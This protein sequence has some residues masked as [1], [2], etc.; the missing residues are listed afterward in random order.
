[1]DGEGDQ[2]NDDRNGSSGRAG[3]KL[4]QSDGRADRQPVQT[5]DAQGEREQPKREAGECEDEGGR[6]GPDDRAAERGRTQHDHDSE[7]A[8]RGATA[9]LDVALMR[10]PERVPDGA[11]EVVHA[12]RRAPHGKRN[13][14]HEPEGGARRRQPQLLLRRCA[15]RN[16]SAM[17]QPRQTS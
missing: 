2:R 17:L 10:Q 6:V 13:R 7:R 15:G 4:P 9:R 3:Q 12:C 5:G 8:A 1:V 11:I 16:C 14:D